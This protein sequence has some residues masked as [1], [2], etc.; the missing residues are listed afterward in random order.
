MLF[1]LIMD[2]LNCMVVKANNEGLLLPLATQNIHHRVSLYADDVVM[3]LHPVAT[4]LRMVEDLLQL[5]GT[6]TDLRTNIP[7]CSVMPIQ[8]YEDDLAIV[9]A[10]LPC[11]VQEF[12]CKYLGLPLSIRKLTRAQLQPLIDKIAEKLPWWK[13]DLNRAGRA[14]YVQHGY[15]DLHCYCHGSAPLVSKGHR[16]N[17]SKLSMARKKRS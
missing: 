16:Q 17:L 1:I 8:S 3:F 11:E 15:A 4:D 6:D 13:A 10:H 12:P 5:F 2:V 7:K 14:V 9:N